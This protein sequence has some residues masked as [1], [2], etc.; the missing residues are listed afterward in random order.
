MTHFYMT[1]PSNSSSQFFPNN[2]MANFKT[3]L[4]APVSLSGSWECALVDINFP[5]TWFTI[6]KDSAAFKVSCMRC[7]G[8]DPEFVETI[9]RPTEY[10]LQ[11]KIPVGYYD[12]LEDL[13]K[14]INNAIF[15][16]FASPVIMWDKDGMSKEVNE[17]NY[18]KFRYNHLNK[19]TIVTLARNM[20]VEFN[21]ILLT[22]LGFTLE[23]NPLMNYTNELKL[24][25]RSAHVGD[26]TCGIHSIYVYASILE[27]LIVGDKLVPLLRIVD[28]TGPPGAM[29]YRSFDHLRYM[30][31]Q[32][33]ELDALE[34]DIRDVYGEPILFESGT[35]VLTLHF[36]K[37]ESQ[38]F[39]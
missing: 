21:P 30:P 23:Q 17:P 11:L 4:H 28:A 34:L 32:M 6:N 5:K 14:A 33:K 29:L 16:A 26:I 27:H 19:R 38:Y 22:I 20:S 18:P 7:E 9:T 25:I 35:L 31:I 36:R 24:S 12:D 1:L 15:T 37:S 10:M 8:S 2:T 39:T 3:K 13:V